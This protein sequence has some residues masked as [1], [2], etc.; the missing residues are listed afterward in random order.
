VCYGRKY[1]ALDHKRKEEEEEIVLPSF[2][3]ERGKGIEITYKT[4]A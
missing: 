4:K 3:S 1:I 2:H